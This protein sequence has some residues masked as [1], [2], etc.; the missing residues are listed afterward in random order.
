MT[1]N[2]TLKPWMDALG[3][4]RVDFAQNLATLIYLQR[5]VHPAVGNH[6]ITRTRVYSRH[7]RIDDAEAARR[8]EWLQI[9]AYKGRRTQ[10]QSLSSMT[11]SAPPL[12]TLSP[13]SLFRTRRPES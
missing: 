12:L 3:Q 5:Q 10:S 13:W 2:Q 6:V 8:L 7:G 9:H 4:D 1:R 11:P